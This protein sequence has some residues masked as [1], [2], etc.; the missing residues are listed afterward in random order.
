[1]IKRSKVKINFHQLSIIG[2]K[3]HIF[4]KII[5]IIILKVDNDFK[6]RVKK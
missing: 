2:I 1:M 3:M 5:K 4:N 6:I